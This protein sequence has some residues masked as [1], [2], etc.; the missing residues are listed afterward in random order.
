VGNPE[1]DL[2]F[3]RAD[4]LEVLPIA[5][6][7]QATEE[8]QEQGWRLLLSDWLAVLQPLLPRTLRVS[9]Y[10]LSL[11]LVQD[12]AVAEL[13]Q[14]WRHRAGPTDVLS[15]AA[16]ECNGRFDGG[17][18]PSGEALELGDIV[19]AANTACRQA[20]EAGHSLDHELRWLASH[21]LLHL[22]GWDHP[23]EL[24]LGRMLTL[25]EQLLS[26]PPLIPPGH[27]G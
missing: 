9:T 15:F 1:L 3:H 2:A 22:L 12:E 23:D 19:I 16:L 20:V 17:F 14:T 24:A 4:G 5:T 26:S 7:G 25:Q 21:G 6:G 13:N 18:L 10:S 8:S 27:Q 11:Q